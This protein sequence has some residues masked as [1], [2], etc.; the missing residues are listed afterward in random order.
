M[1]ILPSASVLVR[2]WF[3][4]AAGYGSQTA[5]EGLSA[6]AL[7]EQQPG[8]AIVSFLADEATLTSAEHPILAVRVLPNREDDVFRGF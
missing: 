3:G 4:D 2:T 5:F 1:A 7:R 8:G 6:E